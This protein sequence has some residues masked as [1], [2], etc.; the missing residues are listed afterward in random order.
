MSTRA[1]RL[2]QLLD[3]LQH[4]RQPVQGAVL[5]AE[6]GISL[7]TLYRDIDSLRVQGADIVG[8]AGIGYQMRSGVWMPAMRFSSV[9]LEALVLGMRWVA[10]QGDGEL[11]VG[12][13]Q[14]LQRI[15]AAL[16]PDLRLEMETSG[17]FAPPWGAV[18]TEPWV[19]TLRQAMRASHR[20][21]LRYRDGQGTATERVIW[22]FALAFSV[23]VRVLAAWCE[24]R[25]DFRHFRAER[26]IS[27]QDTGE[28][29]PKPRHVLLQAWREMMARER[30]PKASVDIGQPEK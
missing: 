20:V 30:P 19:A 9:E 24:L 21:L 3:H 4:R 26:I 16:P 13:D 5:A 23:N 27:V 6:L 15:T 7:R 12:A 11:A 14:A 28:R 29:Y 18:P 10:A 17:L 8:E 2:L 1:T 22:P 25:G